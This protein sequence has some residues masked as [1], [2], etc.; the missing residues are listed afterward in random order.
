MTQTLAEFWQACRTALP[1]ETEGQAYRTRQFG[2]NPEIARQLLELILAREKTGTFAVDW[3]FDSRPGERPSPGDLFV[4]T[5]HAGVPGAL[6]RITATEV[7][8][9]DQISERH[10]Q[11]EG[12][13]LR[14]VVPWRQVHWDYW[15][16][17][18]GEIG[19]EPAADMPILYQEFEL[20]YPAA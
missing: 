4:I 9:F 6:V 1:A 15:T 19:R 5:D 18:L 2:N 12:P 20:L 10:V 11:C 3:E 7:V 17:T 16:R 8:P 14:A 13:A